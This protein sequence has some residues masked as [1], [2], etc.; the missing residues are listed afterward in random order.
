MRKFI[1]GLILGAGASQRVGQPKQLLPYKGTTLLGWVM[2]QVEGAAGLDEVV[3]VL[4]RAADEVR[5]R[6][7]FGSARVVAN[8]VFGE[9]CASSYRAGIGAL[10]PRSE[11]IMIVLGDQPG[12]VP[13]IIDRAAEEWRQ[14]DGQITLCSYRG[15]LGHPMIFA[16][17]LFD[18]L[19]GLHGDKAAWKL[20][21]AN[22]DLVREVSFDLPP[23]ED[24]NTLADFERLVAAGE[25]ARP[26]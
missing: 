14:G 26:A 23:P 20:I 21:D 13:E 17:S 2:A 8:P 11:A 19:A 5:R 7:D 3:V 12:T 25:S 24:I 18:Q 9:G 15:R 6:V 4:G 22:P 10:D 1:S 16:K